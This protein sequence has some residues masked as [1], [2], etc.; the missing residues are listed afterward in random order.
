LWQLKIKLSELDAVKFMRIVVFTLSA[1]LTACGGPYTEVANQFPAKSDFPSEKLESKTLVLTGTNRRG[2]QNLQKIVDV[3]L[4]NSGIHFRPDFPFGFGFP[5]AEVP[6]DAIS[7][8]GMTCFNKD[9]WDV[10]LLLGDLGIEIGISQT[11]E[12]IEWC[13]ERGLPMISGKDKRNWMYSGGRLPSRDGYEQV[14]REEY[15][16]QTKRRCQGY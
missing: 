15:R 6:L 11:P 10:D 13:W 12:V 7:G 5:P 2:A 8:C 14:D 16:Q 9:R 4:D 3:G 1:V